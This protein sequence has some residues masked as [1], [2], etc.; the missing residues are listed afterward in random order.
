[1][2][3]FKQWINIQK[4]LL[5]LCAFFSMPFLLAPA[6][7]EPAGDALVLSGVVLEQGHNQLLARFT[8]WL[9]KKADYPLNTR[10][11]D[12]YQS[13][14]DSLREHATCLAWTCGA[15]FV[16]D[17]AR[18]GQQLIAVP[19]FH[20]KPTY[21]SL[22]LTR[23]G[24]S[25]KTLADF[26]G[27]VFAYSD[28]RSNSGFIAPSFALQQQGLDIND[29]F[30]YL[31]HTG[32]HEYSIEALLSGQADVASIDEYVVVEYFKAHPAAKDKLVILEQFGP[33]PFTP[34]VGGSKVPAAAIARLQHALVSMHEDPAGAA[35]LKEFGLDG[36]VVKPVSFYQP[37][38]DMLKALEK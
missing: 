35:M 10:F 6:Y 21:S 38:A 25:E 31:M 24:R 9:S 19:L 13:L 27:Q 4:R 22:L 20:G 32:L 26:K 2:L 18:D 1:M 11:T 8:D 17:Q 5:L 12:S 16:Q 34:I 33:F 37:I 23:A 36:F 30:R 28:P 7:A 3:L 14:T 15:P 29:Y